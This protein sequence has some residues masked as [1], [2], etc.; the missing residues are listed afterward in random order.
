M[1]FETFTAI[2]HLLSHLEQMLTYML[3][4]LKSD[5]QNLV[6]LTPATCTC[7]T[8]H[9]SIENHSNDLIGLTVAVLQQKNTSISLI[10][11][12]LEG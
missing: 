6:K 3:S 10:I 12:C 5:F 1:L 8:F 2:S 4:P 11:N 9:S 7:I